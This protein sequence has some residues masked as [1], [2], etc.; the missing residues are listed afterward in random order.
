MRDKLHIKAGEFLE[1]E[2]YNGKIILQPV[3]VIPSQQ[4]YFHTEEWQKGEAQADRDIV[5]GHIIGPFEKAEDALKSLKNLKNETY[6][7]KNICKRLYETC[8]LTYKNK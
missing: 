7:H 5:F 8:Q 4:A 2:E 3:Q 1:A 6:I